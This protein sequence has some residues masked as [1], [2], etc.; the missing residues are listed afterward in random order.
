[1]DT[2]EIADETADAVTEGDETADT[3]AATEEG[4]DEAQCATARRL[5]EANS[6]HAR[7]L[8]EQA[9]RKLM[10][11]QELKGRFEEITAQ[12]E[13]EESPLSENLKKLGDDDP[14]LDGPAQSSAEISGYS[15]E[16]A[17]VEQGAEIEQDSM[18]RAALRTSRLRYVTNFG[19]LALAGVLILAPPSARWG[20][21]HGQG[22][23]L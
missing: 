3:E 23:L 8:C 22:G 6:G 18:D 15:Y 13:E 4:D 11:S 7:R 20:F 1:M 5:C 9:A 10:C 16:D 14:L 17:E 21:C 2:G 19:K 12:Y